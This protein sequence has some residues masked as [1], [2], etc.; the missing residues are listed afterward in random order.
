VNNDFL[1]VRPG[2]K[3]T[4]DLW[5]R[6]RGA[7]D[8]TQ[9]LLGGENV[10]I[11][12]TPHGTLYNAKHAGGWVHPWR[13][14]LSRETV[15]VFPGLINGQE[16]K[17]QDTTGKEVPLSNR[18]PPHLKIG[19]FGPN[20]IGWIALELTVDNTYHKIQ[21][22]RVVQCA[23]I[24]GSE[25]ATANPFFFYG[26]PGI[27]GDPPRVRYALARIQKLGEGAYSVYQVAMFN[28]NWIAKPP[29]PQ[30]AGTAATAGQGALPR[31]FFW[32]V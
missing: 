13:V 28:L 23:T 12:R 16:P 31:H 19:S 27:P 6:M 4:A 25:L 24:V 10:R 26:N 30:G 17:M 15:T 1:N 5:N 22:A 20:N 32:P 18:P 29:Q 8:A 9:P 21:K 7:A 2:D 11:Q 14:L 3:V